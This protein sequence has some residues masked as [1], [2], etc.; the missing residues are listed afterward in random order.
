MSWT[1]SRIKDHILGANR[2]TPCP[3]QTDAFFEMKEMVASKRA[4]AAA[5]KSQRAAYAMSDLASTPPLN[6][7]KRSVQSSIETSMQALATS[8]VDHA[9]ARLIYAGNLSFNLVSSPHFKHLVSVLRLAPSHY[10][11]PDRHRLSGDLLDTTIRQLQLADKPLR[12]AV[13]GTHGCSIIIDGWDDVQHNHL[14]NL[15]YATSA[16]SFFEGT[17]KLQSTTHEDARSM[18]NIIIEGIDR[19]PIL[20]GVVHVVTDTCST[21]KA[22]WRI[23][24]R[25]RPWITATC[26]APH[27]LSL[28]L[29]D[30]AK[31]PEVAS[32]LVK[33]ESILRVFWGRT[34]WPRTKL[35]ELTRRNHGKPLGLYR[36]KVTRFAGKVFTHAF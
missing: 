36:A 30:I 35:R 5:S 3:A 27:V 28:L 11:L 10:K 8:Q 33:M 18:A 1:V 34:R 19:F 20:G 16:A 17:S 6:P 9:V 32:I 22:A 4:V 13:L 26:C 15:L 14:I 12:D 21:M 2:I 31:I 7:A 25:K 23:V 24:E 29:K